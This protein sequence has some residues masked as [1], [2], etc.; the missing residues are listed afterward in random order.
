MRRINKMRTTSLIAGVSMLALVLLGSA[1]VQS[2]NA[3]TGGST[4]FGSYQ[5]SLEDGYTKYV[6][7]DARTQPDGSAVGQLTFSDQAPIP[8]QDVD[9]TGDPDLKESPSGVYITV[10]FDGLKVDRNKAVMSGT[11]RDAS[12]RRYIGQRVLLVVEDNGDNP[13]TPDKLTWGF[14]NLT[15][16]GWTPSDAELKEDP[17]VGLK[18]IATDAERRDDEGVPYPRVEEITTQ[19][20]PLSSYDF[21][22][23]ERGSGNIQ[24]R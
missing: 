24:V 23:P 22:N 15:E 10:D 17:G 18:W 1:T 8:D 20:F 19:T 21:V 5:F 7:F 9:G 13:E 11:V 2:A 14:Y 12:I 4:A 6:E 3:Q 16:R